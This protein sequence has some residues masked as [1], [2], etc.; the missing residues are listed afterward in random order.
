ME[1]RCQEGLVL[2]FNAYVY[3]Y[4][5]GCERYPFFFFFGTLIGVICGMEA[6]VAEICQQQGSS[7]PIPLS[8]QYL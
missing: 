3:L 8:F 2:W 5:C 7:V 1:K 6:Y 4:V